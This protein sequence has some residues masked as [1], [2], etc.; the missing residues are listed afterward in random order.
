[1]RTEFILNGE[2]ACADVSPNENLLTT[3]RKLKCLS[4]KDGC[5]EGSCG[6]C[7]VWLDQKPV[8]SC[9]IQTVRIAGH[10]VMTL[11]GVQD[12]ALVL[13][14]Y[15]LDEA[16][17]QCGYCIPGLMMTVLALK[18]Q[19]PHPTDAEIDEWINGNLCRCSGYQS[20]RRAIRKY[21]EEMS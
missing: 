6:A 12:D 15:L 10:E 5:L 1:M 3:L 9:L 17:E 13:G 16:S 4:V 20:R 19:N 18:K 11:E 2:K 21:F 8:L 7:T 14:R